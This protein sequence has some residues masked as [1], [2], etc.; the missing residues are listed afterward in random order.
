[1]SPSDLG[2]TLK[3]FV[4]LDIIDAD[5]ATL[6]AIPNGD[7]MPI[8]L[9]SGV[10]TVTVFAEGPALFDDP[11]NGSGEIAYGGVKWMRAVGVWLGKEMAVGDNILRLRGFQL[12]LALIKGALDA[13]EPVNAVS[14]ASM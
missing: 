7:G 2:Q 5:E 9:H 8:H 6:Q 12:W 10:A 1:M 13:G 11:D 4:F 3:P 14:C